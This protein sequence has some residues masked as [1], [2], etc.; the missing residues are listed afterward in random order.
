MK[1]VVLSTAPS[2]A[3]QGKQRMK[4]VL[5]EEKAFRQNRSTAHPSDFTLDA[6]LDWIPSDAPSKY[7]VDRSLRKTE[8]HDPTRRDYPFI[9]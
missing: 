4:T 9:V 8:T 1:T 2:E 6:V 7:E 3:R 5:L